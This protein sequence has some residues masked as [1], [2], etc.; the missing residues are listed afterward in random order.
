MNN[1][2]LSE[3]LTPFKSIPFDKIE[4]NH[5]MPAFKVSI[6]KAKNDVEKIISN[7]DTPNFSN[8]FEALE[9]AGQELNIISSTFFNLDSAETNDEI[10]QIAQEISPL[11]AEYGNDILL[12]EKLFEKINQAYK[13]TN[14]D[15]LNNEQKR[16]LEK[17][18]KSFTRNGALLEESAK[19]ELREI[20]Q[21]LSILTLQFSQ[22][23]LEETNAYNLQ[24]PQANEIEGIPQSILQAAEELAKEK[25]LEGWVFTL[26]FPSYVPFMKYAQNR[27]LR[28]K[29]YLAYSTRAN[30]ANEYNNEKII[31]EIVEL[32]D[33][34]SQILGYKS[35]AE[36]VLTERM[37]S[38]PQLVYDFL[39]NLLD[40]AKP[41]AL[42]EVQ[43]LQELAK[44][45]GIEEL[46][47]YDH[48]FYSEKLREKT[49]QISEE[50]LKPYFPL[51]QVLEAA[52][53][54]AN[55]LFNLDFVERKDIPVY[56]KEVSVFEVLENQEHK[57]LLYTDWHPRK[58]K[59]PGAWMTS[60]KGQSI[61]NTINL[62]PHISIVCNFSRPQENTPSLLT[63]NEVT[64]LF[65]EFG[66]ALHG[67]MANTQYES[68]SGTQVYWDFVE[69]P[70]Q[71]M[72]N[73]CYEKE[74]LKTFAKHYQ[75][76]EILADS[77][78]D[79][80]AASSNFMEGY[81]TVRQI[82]LGLLDLAYHDGENLKDINQLSVVDFENKQLNKTQLYPAIPNTLISTTFSHI[83]AGGYSAGYYSYKWA[84]VL[85]ADAF[86]YFKEKGI[87]NADLGSKFKTLLSKGGTEDPMDLYIE[88]RGRKPESQALL[89]RAGLIEK[90]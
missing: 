80:I 36:Y 33:K 17:T 32:R 30:L 68:L 66:H 39:G 52:F 9:I 38:N 74:F 60:F 54:L 18:Y 31:K 29:M 16:L 12:N 41:F 76:G 42:K 69:L 47:P 21:K 35:H 65:H 70:S 7:S 24:V 11:L 13:N 27:E 22:N 77:E 73:F 61:Q 85:D 55:K 78:I 81:Q 71:F 90:I 67:I 48:S 2:L 46:M 58:G 63:F 51:E 49:F 53:S 75:N 1:P 40:K 8:T 25:N 59:R 89:K 56:H 20:D 62:R 87:L 82:G 14:S 6:E 10:Q 34:R 83:F 19:K 57:A 45:E 72:E 37:A 84:E 50:K 5:F 23:V 44:K 28:K 26:Q 86:E 88:F 15:L 3:F 43:A 4:N 64:T 79:K